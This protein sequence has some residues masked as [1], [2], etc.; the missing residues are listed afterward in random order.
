MDEDEPDNSPDSIKL[1]YKTQSQK[2]QV[3]KVA[4]SP[5]NMRQQ[6]APTTDPTLNIPHCK[7][8]FN[9]QLNYDLDAAL[10]PDS[11]NGNFYIVSLHGSIKHLASDIL[12]I[13]ESLTR[14]RK[15]I[16]SK[17]I[18]GDKANDIKDL[19]SIGKAIWKFISIV[20]NSHWDSLYI[21]NKNTTFRSKVKSKFSP[22]VKNIQPLVNK[23]KEVAK[24]S[25]VLVMLLP[26]P[27]KLN[28]EVKENLKFFKKIEKPATNKSYTQALLSK[29]KPNVKNK[30]SRLNIF[31]HI[32]IFSSIYFLLFYF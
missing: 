24:P 26:I 29:S 3:S 25:F 18:N 4:N 14:M 17:S 8:V 10:N 7:S 15:F 11:W 30:R 2:H 12:N 6:Y 31:F 5:S 32:V 23:G 21:D 1:E 9:V 20:Y 19:N 27:A 16:A 13:K 28:K 22:Q